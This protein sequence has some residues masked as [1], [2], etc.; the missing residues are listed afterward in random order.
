[1]NDNL[2]R[3]DP[4]ELLANLLKFAENLSNGRPVDDERDL[5]A[6]QAVE[7]DSELQDLLPSSDEAIDRHIRSSK[8]AHF[9]IHKHGDPVAEI[10]LARTAYRAGETVVGVVKMN[11]PGWRLQVLKVSR[12]QETLGPRDYEDKPTCPISL[13]RGDITHR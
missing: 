10:D 13:G 5:D 12:A 9:D 11:D 2:P 4:A 1:V 7:T 6:Q 3:K 8:P